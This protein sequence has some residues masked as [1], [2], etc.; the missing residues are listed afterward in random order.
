MFILLGNVYVADNNNNRVR[1]VVVSTGIISTI[2]GTGTSGYSGDGN[3]ATSATLFYPF[4]VALDSS[5]NANI[6]IFI[7]RR[8]VTLCFSRE[9]VYR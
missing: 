3:S 7:Y 4:G 6:R 1:K 2:A 8:I 9:R 5:G